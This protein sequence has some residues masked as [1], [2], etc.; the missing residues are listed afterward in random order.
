MTEKLMP[1]HDKR[2]SEWGDS[3]SEW[4]EGWEKSIRL[5]LGLK[6]NHAKPLFRMHPCC[7]VLQAEVASTL[8]HAITVHPAILPHLLLR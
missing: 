8:L 3:V 2:L 4:M 1:Y 6:H 7:D 5:C